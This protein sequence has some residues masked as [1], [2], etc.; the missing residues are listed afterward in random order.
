MEL[1]WV[2]SRRSVFKSSLRY[3]ESEIDS[4]II[5]LQQFASRHT[6]YKAKE[7]KNFKDDVIHS[8]S[9]F[10]LESSINDCDMQEERI[11]VPPSGEKIERNGHNTANLEERLAQK[12]KEL[13]EEI[14][15]R[16]QCEKELQESKAN[17][18][19]DIAR[20]Q[21][22]IS[23]RQRHM[24][25]L[26]NSLEKEKARAQQLYY[27]VRRLKM[28]NSALMSSQEEFGVVFTDKYLPQKIASKCKTLFREQYSDARYFLKGKKF[29]NPEVCNILKT[30]FVNANTLT[31]ETISKG[32]KAT[33]EAIHETLPTKYFEKNDDKNLPQE[34]EREF[35]R[36]LR[37]YPSKEQQECLIELM[38]PYHHFDA[39]DKCV[40]RYVEECVQVTWLMNA[41][42]PP[43]Y[44]SFD[45]QSVCSEKYE[46]RDG[47]GDKIRYWIWPCI[48]FSKEAYCNGED[49]MVM[50]V[51]V[52]D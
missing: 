1:K 34:M 17:H 27:E 21:H 29:R 46:V 13:N 24:T 47:T 48:Y 52:T 25:K 32:K 43:M 41:S 33:R 12:E 19:K 37:Q 45:D 36:R 26:T 15:K 6:Q 7:I 9:M 5:K 31:M 4:F 44:A 14:I 22:E 51:V 38:K 23:N 11:T 3:L 16:K 42:S 30:I 50:G 35:S 39:S 20:F 8:K 2:L 49:V 10:C 28:K 40:R 18:Q